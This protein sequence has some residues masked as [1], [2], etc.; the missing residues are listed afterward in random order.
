M[1]QDGGAAQNVWLPAGNSWYN[2]WADIKHTG[3]DAADLPYVTRTGEIILFVK[4]GAILPKYQYAQSTAYLNKRQLELEV[5]AGADG[6]FNLVEDDGVT[7]SHRVSGARSVTALTWTDAATR[8]VIRHPQGT[9]AGAPATRRYVV[10][11][12]GL[13]APAGM[14]VNGGGTLPAFT[15]EAT[16]ITSGGGPCGTPPGRS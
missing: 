9:Y 6:G 1:T 12:H 8:T 7:E 14:R 13:A 4:A 15:T 5:Y 10:R 2:F 11:I 16:A 3:T